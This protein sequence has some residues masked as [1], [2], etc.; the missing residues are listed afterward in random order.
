MQKVTLKAI[1]LSAI[2]MA[3]CS[4][5]NITLQAEARVNQTEADEMASTLKNANTPADSIRILYDVYDLSATG[6]RKD[7]GLEILE[8][9]QRT[10]NREVIFDI[11]NRLSSKLDDSDALERLIKISSSLPDSQKK[12]GLELVLQMEKTN[13]DVSDLTGD[14]RTKK[15][16]DYARRD[17]GNNDD[18][19]EEIIDLYHT[20]TYLGPTSQGSMYLEYLSR[21]ENLVNE[22]PAEDFSIRNLYYTNAAIYYTHRRNYKKAI[23]CD[24]ELL[25]QIDAL[26]QRYRDNKTD[27]KYQNYDYFRYVSLRRM[28]SN[29]K[30]LSEAETDSIFNKCIELAERNEE[31]GESFGTRGM[32]KSY[33]YMSKGQYADAIPYLHRALANEDISDF[34]RQELLAYLADAQKATG[35]EKGLFE[36]LQLYVPLLVAERQAHEDDAYRE[37]EIK[38][39]VNRLTIEE[40]REQE[41][42]RIENRRMRRISLSLVYIFAIILIILCRKY[43]KLKH[44]VLDLEMQ[45]ST[46]HT[47]IEHIFDDGMPHGTTDVRKAKD[48]LKG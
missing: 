25:H 1:A 35:D 5:D 13:S 40:R 30:G 18:I 19:Y 2:M 9:A 27:R 37:L 26:E 31:V 4:L 33:Y 39:T 38:T 14:E 44:K 6:N 10:N 16:I 22:L 41:K 12:K 7:V 45:N 21:L 15:L 34:R 3:S 36:T 48:K 24:K 8:I 20:L 23:E 42:Q 47:N 32:S 17:I 29:F 28:L 46:L 43:F 11:V